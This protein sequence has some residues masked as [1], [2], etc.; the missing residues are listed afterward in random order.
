MENK[1]PGPVPSKPSPEKS[2]LESLDFAAPVA[3]DH[4]AMMEP[5]PNSGNRTIAIGGHIAAST[6]SGQVKKIWLLPS[7]YVALELGD[8]VSGTQN[9]ILIGPAQVQKVAVKT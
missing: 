9:V 3:L 8:A 4:V 6:R 2:L 5:D 1:Q 7:G